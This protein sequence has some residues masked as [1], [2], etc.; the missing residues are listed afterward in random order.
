MTLH[1]SSVVFPG[2]QAEKGR[3]QSKVASLEVCCNRLGN[4]HQSLA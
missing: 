3:L 1:S 2:M 4:N